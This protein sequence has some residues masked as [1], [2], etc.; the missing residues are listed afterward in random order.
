MSV[1]KIFDL[2]Q[3]YYFEAGNNYLGSL[4][5]LNFKID[6]NENLEIYLYYGI[7][8]FE[9]SE[10]FKHKTFPNDKDGYAD[11]ISW[12][13]NEYLQHKNTSHYKTRFSLR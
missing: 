12:L 8:C 6:S 7:K 5:G 13:E 3:Y 9:L 2:P 11:L 10:T 4:N 1:S